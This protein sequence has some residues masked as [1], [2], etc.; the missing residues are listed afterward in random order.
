M[1]YT[2]LESDIVGTEANLKPGKHD[3]AGWMGGYEGNPDPKPWA[4]IN[5]TT[6]TITWEGVT[7]FSDA[8]ALDGNEILPVVLLGFTATYVGNE[9]VKLSWMTSMEENND[10]FTI[11][12][13][14]DAV[15]FEEILTVE[16]AGDSEGLKEYVVYDRKPLFGNSYYR[17]KQTDFDGSS[18]TFHVVHVQN[19]LNESL[20]VYPNPVKNHKVKIQGAGIINEATVARVT[21]ITGKDIGIEQSIVGNSLHLHFPETTRPGIYIASIYTPGVGERIVRIS[22]K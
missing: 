22:K 21:T 17:L 9:G 5:T 18:E 10:Y 2:Y 7:S 8:S 15:Q 14:A 13:S 6:N 3:G 16:G 4:T 1:V 19:V 12:R 20:L 11:E